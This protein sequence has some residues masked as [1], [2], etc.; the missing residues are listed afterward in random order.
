[1]LSDL[2]GQELRFSLYKKE[3]LAQAVCNAWKASGQDRTVSKTQSSI[4]KGSPAQTNWLYA[5]SYRAKKNDAAFLLRH[6]LVKW[7]LCI[8]HTS[9]ETQ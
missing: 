6:M 7:M 9:G 5:T 2:V 4:K 8:F 3:Q 1:M